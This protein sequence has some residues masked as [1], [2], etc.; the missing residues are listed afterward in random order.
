MTIERAGSEQGPT[1]RANGVAKPGGL[2]RHDTTEAADA[3]PDRRDRVEISDE[4]RALVELGGAE[5]SRYA[6]ILERLSSG[7]YHTEAVAERIAAR[8]LPLMP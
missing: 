5:E 8:I 4:G 3:A 1:P 2:E 7:A 6:H